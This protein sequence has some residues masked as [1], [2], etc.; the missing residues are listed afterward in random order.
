MDEIKLEPKTQP[1]L[2]QDC[3]ASS[4]LAAKTRLSSGRVI[5]GWVSIFHWE[6]IQYFYYNYKARAEK[7]EYLRDQSIRVL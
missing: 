2:P 7:K 6:F 4:L 5:D 3:R 1:Q